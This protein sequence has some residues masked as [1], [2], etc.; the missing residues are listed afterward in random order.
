MVPHSDEPKVALA[1]LIDRF[2]GMSPSRR[3]PESS[4]IAVTNDCN[5]SAVQKMA[6]LF[7]RML[8]ATPRI[9]TVIGWP[10]FLDASYI[11]LLKQEEPAALVVLAYYGVTLH[12]LNHI[13]WLGGLGT[14]LVQAVSEIMNDEWGPYLIWPRTEVVQTGES[15]LLYGYGW[16]V[17]L[18]DLCVFSS[19]V[20]SMG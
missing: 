15:G 14:R 16:V 20:S 9:S 7:P 2:Q 12:K 17:L 4:E 6:P 18:G 3:S 11:S 5:V 19:A 8:E 1:S 10:V 13:W